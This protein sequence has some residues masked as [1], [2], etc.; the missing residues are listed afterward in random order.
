M[1]ELNYVKL[2]PMPINFCKV[3]RLIHADRLAS[4]IVIDRDINKSF[5][6]Y[7]ET[8]YEFLEDTEE[9]HKEVIRKN[10]DIIS[11]K[12]MD[13]SEFIEE[14]NLLILDYNL[15]GNCYRKILIDEL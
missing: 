9:F 10:G 15:S 12:V 1:S 8:R 7:T 11:V 5:D 4:I 14:I 13:Q 3:K 6:D 2:E